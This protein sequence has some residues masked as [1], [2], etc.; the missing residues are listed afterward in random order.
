MELPNKT[1]STL[2]II[3]L[4]QLVRD[5]KQGQATCIVSICSSNQYVIQTAFLH[6][7]K[8]EHP[9]LIESTCNQV[10]QLGGYAGMTPSDFVEYTRKLAAQSG[11]PTERLIL[12]GDHLGPYPWQKEPAE[13]A[14]QKAGILVRDYVQSGYTKIH[15]DTSMPC[16][17]DQTGAMQKHVVAQRTAE[18]ARI[19][20]TT[21]QSK[22]S[23]K[24]QLRYVIG[25]EVPTPG[26]M[27]EKMGHLAVSQAGDVQ[28]TIEV[29]HQAFTQQGLENAWERVTAVVVHP[30]VEFGDQVI[31]VYDPHAAQ[32]LSRL[33]ENYGHLVYEAHSTD[34]QPAQALENM[35]R[36]HFAI[37]KVGP[38]LTFALREALFA[39]AMVEEEL[40][41]GRTGVERSHLL[42][43]VE[44]A[45]LENPIHWQN[46]Y[47]GDPNIQ[48]F[49]RRYSLSDRIRY[50]WAVPKVQA[51]IEILLQNLAQSPPPLSLLSQFFPQQAIS[52]RNGELENSP[53]LLIL[54]RIM[55]VLLT[56]PDN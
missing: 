23:G 3:H 42:D 43:V 8:H 36:D 27:V 54:D 53:Q 33:I 15:L 21:W 35:A 20:E 1:T 19:A 46:Y 31:Y 18:L 38:A 48:R 11:F 40:L 28:E 51:A 39:L 5:Q 14:M 25:S 6:A 32:G 2:P 30:G 45:M 22:A 7:Q 12:G 34:Y 47:T 17:G 16:H 44:E 41:A 52:I 49:S 50:Y 13:L 55:Q 29:T 10:N 9:V 24:L 37:L 56:Y 26:G 4:D